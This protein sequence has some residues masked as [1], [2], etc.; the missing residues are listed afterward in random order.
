M[1]I[2]LAAVV[3]LIAGGLYFSGLLSP[4]DGGARAV[5][6][7]D[8]EQYH[9][10]PLNKD[11]TFTVEK[12]GHKNVVAVRDG[13]VHMEEASCPDKICVSQGEI[14][15]SNEM[16]VCL[17]NKVYIEVVDDGEES[18]FDSVAK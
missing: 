16:I 2:I 11:D 8:G 9:T 17:P 14:S 1:D 13:F 3:L 7:V 15:K 4:E 10:M 5:I 6:Y 12:D 18:A